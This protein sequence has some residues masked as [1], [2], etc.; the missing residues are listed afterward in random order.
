MESARRTF[1]LIC[2]L[3]RGGFGEVYLAEMSAG[4]GVSSRVAAKVLRGELAEDGQALRRLQDEARALSRLTHPS[5]LK[6]HD[7]VMLELPQ[8]GRAALITEYV[9]GEDLASC[10]PSLGLRALAEALARVAWALDAAWHSPLKLVHRDVKP[11]NIRLSRHGEVKLLDFGIARAEQMTREAHT[12]AGMMVG[13]LPYMAPER[14]LDKDPDVAAD[15]FSLGCVLLEALTGQRSFDLPMTVMAGLAVEPSRHRAHLESQ[16]A[17]IPADCPESVR[18]LVREL[19]QPEPEARPQARALAERLERM[20]EDLPGPTLARFCRDRAWA[21]PVP[22]TGELSGRVLTEGTFEFPSHSGAARAV[23]TPMARPRAR[24]WPV[25]LLGVGLGTGAAVLASGAVLALLLG[26]VGLWA[27]SRAG[28]PP[29]PSPPAPAATVT[30]PPDA[31]D[32]V[33]GGNVEACYAFIEA[34]NTLP[35]ASKMDPR[36][37]C[38]EALDLVD[39]DMGPH[40]RCR[41]EQRWC[42]GPRIVDNNEICPG[43]CDTK[44]SFTMG[45]NERACRDYWEAY[46]ALECTVDRPMDKLCDRSLDMIRCDWKSFYECMGA[47]LSCN[48]FG[49]TVPDCGAVACTP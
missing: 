20:A 19:L 18:S 8:G 15:V 45:P 34:N 9:E 35:C 42:D 31:D 37:V 11:G 39:C 33:P 26:G 49:A 47:G 14:F 5:I 44:R 48:E 17:T 38:D 46:N 24:W 16:L 29:A 1:S 12:R 27:A 23:G 7:L 2:C 30:R 3:G 21:D 36:E 41:S 43:L 6:V 10:L 22:H 13:S 28:P 25:A 40:Y 32:P 4:G